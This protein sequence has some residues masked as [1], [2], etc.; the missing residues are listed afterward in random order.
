M[1]FIIGLN[2]SALPSFTS[3]IFESEC[4]QQQQQ[5]NSKHVF[6]SFTPERERESPP[7]TMLLYSYFK[8]GFNMRL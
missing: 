6:P 4:M 1:K 2:Y 3:F 5:Q 8:Y 7:L